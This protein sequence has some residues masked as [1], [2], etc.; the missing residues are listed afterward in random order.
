MLLGVVGCPLHVGYHIYM[1]DTSPYVLHTHSLVGFPVHL[2]VLGISACGMGNIPLILAVWGC[3]P[4]CWVWGHQHHWVSICFIMSHV[5]TM[6]MTS[7]PPVTMVSSQLS[8]ISSVTMALSLMGLPAS[9]GQYEVFLPPPLM[10][11][12]SRGVTDLASVLQQQPP[13]LMPL[14]AYANYAMGSP[15]VGFFFRVEPPTILY[16]ICLVS[17]LVSAFYFQVPSWMLYSPIGAQPLGFDHCNPLEFTHG[18]H[19]CNLVMV[20]GP[21]LMCI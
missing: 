4:M 13:S 10:T 16:I 1:L 8:S 7:T 20:I 9:L 12:G 5:S 15:Q 17:I 2:Y 18:R 14:L 11:R 6:A 21:C 3:S 19:M